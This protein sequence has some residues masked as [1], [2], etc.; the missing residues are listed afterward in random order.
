MTGGLKENRPLLSD[1]GYLA[2]ADP[3]AG[4]HAY[5]LVA[6]AGDD[7]NASFQI[8]YGFQ[9][10]TAAVLDFE[11]QSVFHV[12]VRST[13]TATGLW[14]EKAF[15]IP[16][17]DVNELPADVALSGAAV[18]EILASGTTVGTLSTADPDGGGTFAYTL[19][20]GA[21]S[22]DNAS[23]SIDGDSLLTAAVFDY[24]VKN[25]YSVRVRSTDQGGMALEKAFTI[26]VT[27]VAGPTATTLGI[28]P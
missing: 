22:T 17:V 25:S 6:G 9:L 27:D 7:D 16:L 28:E 20:A 26:T 11:T 19:A 8:L 3:E 13:N 14:I 10:R 15:T 1:A 5:E 24:E 18:R 21:G 2:T 12:R 23:F 4:A